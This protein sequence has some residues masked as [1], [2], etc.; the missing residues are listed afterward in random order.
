[1]NEGR[2][3]IFKHCWNDIEFGF[4]TPSSLR[5]YD[6]AMKAFGGTIQRA[7]CG[8]FD[9]IVMRISHFELVLRYYSS[10]RLRQNVEDWV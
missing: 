3:G 9:I 1:M 8:D 7:Y 5:A 6:L 4:P 2:E 10:R